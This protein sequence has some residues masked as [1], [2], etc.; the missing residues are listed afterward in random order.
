[1]ANQLMIRFGFKFY[2]LVYFQTNFDKSGSDSMFLKIS[3]PQTEPMR[4]MKNK[5]LNHTN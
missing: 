4:L 1:M 2:Q 5:I 3:E